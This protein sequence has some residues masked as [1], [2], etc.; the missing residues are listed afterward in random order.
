MNGAL[1]AGPA[2][3]LIADT[4][5]L[6]VPGCFLIAGLLGLYMKLA[7]L[8]PQWAAIARA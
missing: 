5:T 4:A 1:E 6:A 8:G 2:S 7:L 3:N